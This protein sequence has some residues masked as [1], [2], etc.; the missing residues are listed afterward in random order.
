MEFQIELYKEDG[1]YYAYIG[2]DSMSGYKI[3]ASDPG[4]RARLIGEYFDQWD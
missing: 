3:E 2:G 1:M 4:E